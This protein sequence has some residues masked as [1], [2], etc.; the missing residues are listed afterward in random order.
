MARRLNIG[1]RQAWQLCQMSHND[2]LTL[3][4][5]GLPILLESARAFWAASL[6]LKDKPREAEVLSGFAE[7]EA[8]KTLILIDMVRCPPKV[9]AS[10]VGSIVGWFYD[11]LARLIYAEAVSWKP[12]HVAQLREYVDSQRKAHYLEGHGEYI[13]PNWNVF[14]RESQLYADIEAYEDGAPGWNTPTCHISAVPAFVPP[15]LRVAEAL[16]VVGIFNRRGLVA[17][18]DIFGQ[19]EFKDTESHW[20]AQRLTE[21]LLKR[22]IAENLPTEAAS[23][24]HIDELYRTW[25]LP[26]YNLDFRQI[27][28]PLAELEK[29]R[30]ALLWAEAGYSSYDY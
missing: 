10:K 3:I 28:V 14:M 18:A 27:D 26:M 13:V 30:D 1:L 7:E 23:G 8:A 9:V 21:E 15:V 17:T 2:R 25:Q 4:G 5:E 20:D 19:L 6:D 12:M 16:S 11:H 22:L 29:E 24:D